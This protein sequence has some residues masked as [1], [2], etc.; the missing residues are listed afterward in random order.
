MARTMVEPMLCRSAESSALTEP[1]VATGMK[2]GVGTSPCGVCRV[3]MRASLSVVVSVKK[4]IREFN[5][6]G[7]AA[8]SII[9]LSPHEAYATLDYDFAS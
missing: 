6:N 9:R 1:C 5:T 8:H 2:A 3:P 4:G 7:Q